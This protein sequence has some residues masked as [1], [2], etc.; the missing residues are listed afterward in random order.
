MKT[1]D[2]KV[3]SPKEIILSEEIA[4][5]LRQLR[6]SY[7]TPDNKPLSMDR[8]SEMIETKYAADGFKLS[9]SSILNYEIDDYE[10]NPKFGKNL[11]MS[12]QVIY[13]LSDFFGV[14]ADYITGKSE[15]KTTDSSL[16]GAASFTGLSEKAVENLRKAAFLHAS[17]LNKILEDDN[18]LMLSLLLRT[19]ETHNE[20]VQEGISAVRNKRSQTDVGTVYLELRD[21]KFNLYELYEDFNELVRNSLKIINIQDSEREL[22]EIMMNSE[23]A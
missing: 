3:L 17:T 7:Q 2:E 23:E 9:K 22:T 4:H 18:I 16:A 1:K 13:Y 10:Y 12:A 20:V 8:M 6:L 11:G 21:L 19:L 14:S 15:V 5:R